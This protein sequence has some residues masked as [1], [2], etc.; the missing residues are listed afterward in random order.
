MW[1]HL[2][3]QL[4]WAI[5][6]ILREA[7]IIIINKLYIINGAFWKQQIIVYLSEKASGSN[8]KGFGSIRQIWVDIEFILFYHYYIDDVNMVW[9]NLRFS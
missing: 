2:S 4:R 6:D 7:Y 9:S 5:N 1:A 8:I 3:S